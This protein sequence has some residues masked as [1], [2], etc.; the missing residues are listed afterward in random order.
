MR[1]MES[2][3]TTVTEVPKRRQSVAPWW[4]T[5]ALILLFVGISFTG[6]IESRTAGSTQH[7]LPRY[8]FTLAFEW[9]AAG[10]T[11]WGLRMRRVPVA[12]VVGEWRSGWNG[13]KNDLAA[14]AI[15]WIMATIL[16]AGLGAA[17]SLLHFHTAQKIIAG[18][19]PQTLPEMLL[20]VAMSVSAGL[21][22]EFI[23]RGY[24][25]QQFSSLT[26]RLWIGVA[27]SSLLFGISH[28]YEGVAGMIV[29]TVYGAMFCA[30]A[31]QRKGLR[32]GM[33]AHAWHDLF[34]GMA[35]ALAH[36][37]HVL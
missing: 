4:H 12:Q 30:L 6:A 11:W 14:A 18:M 10:V 7:H 1:G 21:C 23:F 9:V 33:M 19:A 2:G 25:L 32:A 29:I 16:L 37:F 15:F 3:N 28:G 17:L 24:M 13:W 34:S 20:W 22:E 27:L 35:L 26:N 5:C 31:L 36:H 8:L